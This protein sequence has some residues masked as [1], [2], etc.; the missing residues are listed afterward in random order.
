MSIN[1]L[2]NKL[3]SPITVAPGLGNTGNY[4]IF[5]DNDPSINTT[6]LDIDSIM[7]YPAGTNTTDQGIVEG[8]I[9]VNP[10]VAVPRPDGNIGEETGSQGNLSAGDIDAINNHHPNDG[11]KITV[12]VKD[13]GEGKFVTDTLTITNGDHAIV[14]SGIAENKVRI[15]S[16]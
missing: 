2:V 16:S 5:P 3:G 9:T 10:G 13:V 8:T 12:G 14:V 4:D 6:P 7:G 1:T 15:D 11:T